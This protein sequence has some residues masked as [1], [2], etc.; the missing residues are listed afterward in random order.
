MGR[1]L[2]YGTGDQIP[3]GAV[4]LC[5]KVEP[6]TKVFSDADIT[7][8]DLKTTRVTKNMSVWHYFLVISATSGDQE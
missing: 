6:M 1:V 8:T 2:K 7:N 5:T 4:Y 3:D